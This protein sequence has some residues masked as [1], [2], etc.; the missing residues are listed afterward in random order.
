MKLRT[1]LNS[2]I[3]VQNVYM[4]IEVSAR[5]STIEKTKCS[6]PTSLVRVGT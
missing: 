4:S 6:P 2:K 5:Q 3:N 1:I